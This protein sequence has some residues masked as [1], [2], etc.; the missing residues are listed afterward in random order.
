MTDST[1]IMSLRGLPALRSGNPHNNEA[2]PNLSRR[3]LLTSAAAGP[4]ECSPR[5]LS[6][7]GRA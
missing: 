3:H 4:V 2:M 1:D 7:N 6:P 5:L